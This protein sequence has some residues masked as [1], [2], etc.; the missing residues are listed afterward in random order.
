LV[1]NGANPLPL[2]EKL[3]V[4]YPLF[5]KPARADG[6]IGVDQGSVVGSYVALVRRIHALRRAIPGPVLVEEYLPG[7]EINIAVFPRAKHGIFAPTLVDFAAVPEGY[8]PVVTYEGKW[9]ESSPEFLSRS[10]PITTQIDRDTLD[11]AIAIAKETLV[12][13]DIDSYARVDFRLDRD[14]RPCVMDV[15]PNPALHP[16]AGFATALSSMG[17]PFG[18]MIKGLVDEARARR[19]HARP[20]A[21]AKR[22]AGIGRVALPN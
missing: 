2:P 21:R 3:D 16:T 1:V 7:P 19:S 13:L 20:S 9:V 10:V 15:N 5:V 17:I 18:D 4:R 12:A 6:S 8:W 11:H 14:G 22:P